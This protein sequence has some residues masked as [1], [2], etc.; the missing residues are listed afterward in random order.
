VTS[1]S[2]NY[3]ISVLLTSFLSYARAAPGKVDDPRL[4]DFIKDQNILSDEIMPLI[5]QAADMCQPPLFEDQPLEKMNVSYHL[6]L[7]LTEVAKLENSGSSKWYFPPNCEKIRRE[8]PGI[9]KPDS[10]C[11]RIKNPVNYYFIKMKD[12]EAD[13]TGAEDIKPS[14]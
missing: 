6:G 14:S 10:L 3:A 2:R 8:A 13:E 7:G 11:E 4:V 12:A 9:C 1:G 5:Y